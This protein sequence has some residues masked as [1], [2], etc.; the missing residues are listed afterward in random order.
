MLVILLSCYYL[1]CRFRLICTAIVFKRRVKCERCAEAFRSTD[2][3]NRLALSI[4]SFHV[5]NDTLASRSSCK[6]QCKGK[7]M[8]CIYGSGRC[9]AETF[10]SNAPMLTLFLTASAI[11]FCNI[12]SL[13]SAVSKLS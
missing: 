7:G 12:S 11:L 2:V 3:A 8:N 6:Q 1:G 4:A 9:V 10:L 5:S 13:R